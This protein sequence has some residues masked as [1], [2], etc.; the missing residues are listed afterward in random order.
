MKFVKQFGII[1]VFSFIGEICHFLI[2]FPIPASIY[3]LVFFFIALNMKWISLD[4]VKETGK[5][6]IEI[7]PIMFIPAAVG[8]LDSWE[9]LKPIWLQFV[10]IALVTTI[11]VMGITGRIT[12]FCIRKEQKKG[13]KEGKE[14]A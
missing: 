7:M 3:G 12:Q 14:H 2:S 6:L 4:S 8:L 5:F 1:L 11:L 10:L 9:V 13:K